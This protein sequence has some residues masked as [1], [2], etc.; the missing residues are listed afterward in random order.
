[1]SKYRRSSRS[2]SRRYPAAQHHWA[3][4]LSAL[5]FGSYALVQLHQLFFQ[6]NGAGGPGWAIGQP[7]TQ[8]NFRL[9]NQPLPELRALALEVANRDRQV[10]G[11]P[12]LVEDPLLSQVAQRHAEDMLARQFY[13][14]VNPDGQDPSARYIAAGGQVGAGENIMQQKGTI[15]MALSLGLVEEYQ[16]GWMESPGHRENLLTPRYT[17]FGYGIVAS[18]T[19]TEIYAVQMFSFSAQ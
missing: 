12:P 6:S 7:Q 9:G 17:T 1:M 8:R 4:V 10:N 14:H 2:I 18:A 16:Q 5:V 19:G 11:L 13:D 15:P 3:V